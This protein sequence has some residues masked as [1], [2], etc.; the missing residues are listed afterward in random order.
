MGWAEARR[1]SDVAFG[2]VA[3]QAIFAFRQ[4]NLPAP[5]DPHRIVRKARRR[6]VQS[7]AI[8]S[9]FLALIALVAAVALRSAGTIVGSGFVPSTLAPGLFDAG[10]VTGLLSLDIAFL[11]WTGLQVLPTFLSAEV[12]PVLEPLPIDDRTLRQTAALLYVRLFDLPALTVLVATP[13][14]VG[15]AVGPWAGVAVVPGAVAAVAFALALSLLT[16]R[17][18]VRRVQGARGGGGS[19]A[20]RWAYLLLWVIPAFGLFAFVTAAPALF[21]ALDAIALR[22]PSVPAYLLL[23]AFPFALASLPAVAAQGPA[24]FGLPT[25]GVVLGAAAVGYLALAGWAVVWTLRSVRTFGL[26]PALAPAAGPT[27]RY[28]VHPTSPA[29]AVLVKDLRIASRT[30]G[31]AFLLLL[32][33]LDAAAIGLWTYASASAASA[34]LALG[35]AAVATAALLATFFGPAFF[36]IEVN[37]YSY[38]RALPLPDRAVLLGK[39]ALVALLYLVAAGIVLGLSAARVFDP[40]V[41][42]AFVAAELPA[43]VAASMLALGILF[44][45]ARRRGLPIVNLY[46]GTWYAVLVSIPALI[47]AGVPLLIF[48]DLSA[49]GAYPGL[50]GMGAGALAELAFCAPFALAGGST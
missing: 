47:V 28:D 42:A 4:G 12:L 36:A 27:P 34:A 14:F 29:W 1:W 37:A 32:P 21:E 3:L 10:I 20:L 2:E 31:Y 15:L 6:V 44:H 33:I 9:V 17:F 41:F 7:K 49:A 40:L 5:E 45:R 46:A 39:V 8:I 23:A 22:G 50:A 18:F 43:V 16:A 24:G 19:T 11:W 38:G 30:P 35:L 26:A 25:G 48:H 13:V